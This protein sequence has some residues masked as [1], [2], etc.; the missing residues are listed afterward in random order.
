MKKLK[1]LIYVVKR[2]MGNDYLNR[3]RE[4]YRRNL[5]IAVIA[6]ALVPCFLFWPLST[7]AS[8][9][10]RVIV[11]LS[12]TTHAHP[13]GLLWTKER[14][15]AETSTWQ[16]TTFS[17]RQTYVLPVGYEHAVPA[18]ERP[19]THALDCAATGIGGYST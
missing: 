9:V 15:V 12:D 13:V 6:V 1:L 17:K 3:V 18:S 16:H 10:Q 11:T 14:P 19:Q 8:L 4:F 5:N 2:H 7:Y